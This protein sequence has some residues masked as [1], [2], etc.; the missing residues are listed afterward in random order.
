MKEFAALCPE[1]GLRATSS[2]KPLLRPFSWRGWRTRRWSQ[3]LFGAA[4][5]KISVRGSGVEPW[6]ALL[7]DSRASRG[8]PPESAEE[9]QTTDGYG[10]TSFASSKTSNRPVFSLRMSQASL[11]EEDSTAY[12]EV[13][14]QSGSMRNGVLF[15]QPMWEPRISASEFSFWPST[16]AEDAESCG[17][18]PNGASD[19]LTGVTKKWASPDA[20]TASYSNG[21]GGFQNLREQAAT[22]PT[23]SATDGKGSAAKGQRRGQLD[24]ATEQIFSLPDPMTFDGATLFPNEPTS[25]LPLSLVASVSGGTTRLNLSLRKRLNPAFAAWLMGMPWFWTSIG[26]I[27]FAQSETALWRCRL[28]SRLEFLLRG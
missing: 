10:P 11:L 9:N 4:F 24:E 12:S 23:T 7:R 19:S 20:N 13:L 15:P 21:F 18:H 1:Q 25:R 22:W 6:T 5:L 28:R 14:P 26:P 16:R 27:S 3:H 2:G 8:A 17:N